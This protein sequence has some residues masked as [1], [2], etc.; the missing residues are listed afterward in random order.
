MRKG[1]C[2]MLIMLLVLS[3]PGCKPAPEPLTE[4]EAADLASRFILA[5][6]EADFSEAFSYFD[7]Q[8]AAAISEEQ[9]A[10][11][12]GQLEDQM[13][14][15][16]RSVEQRQ[17]T[18]PPYQIVIVTMQMGNFYLDTRLVFSAQK[19]IAGLFFQPS[20]YL[21]RFYEPPEYADESLD[22]KSVV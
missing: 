17:E 6:A 5:M 16:V 7:S 20:D 21:A 4:D 12:W 19:Q 22:R 14:T 15:Y 9:L 2:I 1:I 18:E 3:V 10:E 13:G 11:I 8:M